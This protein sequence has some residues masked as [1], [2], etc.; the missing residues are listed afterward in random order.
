MARSKK[1][2]PAKKVQSN[3]TKLIAD[4]SK[5]ILTNAEMDKTLK[6]LG[7]TKEDLLKIERSGM[8]TH[9]YIPKA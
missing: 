7:I 4:A 8:G 9:T 6:K 5:G 3:R 1:R 2:K